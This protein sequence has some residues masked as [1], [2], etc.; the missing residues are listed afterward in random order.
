MTFQFCGS[1]AWI[2]IYF[3][4]FC[5][6][7]TCHSTWYHK[8]SLMISY[9]VFILCKTAGS[10]DRSLI[11]FHGILKAGSRKKQKKTN[12]IVLVTLKLGNQ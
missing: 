5:I 9:P 1:K 2:G 10:G 8:C 4:M 7:S 11:L 3:F 6:T 12:N